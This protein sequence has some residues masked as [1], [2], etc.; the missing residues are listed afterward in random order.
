MR[1]HR[2]HLVRIL[3]WLTPCLCS[4]LFAPVRAQESSPSG[5]VAEVLSSFEGFDIDRDSVPEIR[6]LERCHDLE[7]Q[8]AEPGPGDA[9]LL[10]LVEGRLLKPAEAGNPLPELLTEYVQALRE[11]GWLAL[12]IR[13]E[14]YSGE[15]HQDGKTVLALRRML[16]AMRSIQPGF[17]GA[18]LIGSFPE[19]MLVRRWVWKHNTRSVTL[20][21]VKLNSGKGP[22]A[23]W[24][25]MD[26]ELIS[27]RSDIVL[28]DLDGEWEAIY[29]EPKTALDRIQLLP[30]EPGMGW[31]DAET[32]LESSAFRI[33]PKTYEDFFWIDD[34]QIEI[35]EQTEDHLRIRASYEMRRPEIASDDRR[36]PNPIARPEIMISR[37]DARHVAVTQPQ[38]NLDETG[39]PRPVPVA[40]GSPQRQ[41]R[42][43]PDLE[44][45]LL[46][47]YLQRNI[48][49]RRSGVPPEARRVAALTTDLHTPSKRYF[50]GIA[51]NL[52]KTVTFSKATA[53]DAARFLQTPA[54]IKGVSA[55]SSSSCSVLMK[56]YDAGE[57]EAL[58]GGRYWFWRKRGEEF[59]P[60]YSHSSVR[61][62]LH[63][64]LLRTLWTNG[65]LKD[66][67]PAFY[68]HGGCE[69]ISPKNAAKVPY[70]HE[71]YGGHDQIAESL[72]F[73]GNGLAL[74][75]RAKV[76]YDIPRGFEEAFAK[77]TFGDV[78]RRY[79]E[80]ESQDEK[81]GRSVASLNRAYF[82][83]ILG[84][85]TLRLP[86]AQDEPEG[87]KG[88]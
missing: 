88:H 9:L 68:V 19:A 36:Q 59:V 51:R 40:S 20:G 83:S 55:H 4:L 79:F 22:R 39:R 27:H 8:S 50:D 87:S 61:D 31:P 70:D 2:P 69:A 45:Q 37:L 10:I 23:A 33:S 71:S 60:S 30:A 53:V 12:P 56:G 25:A 34:S 54:L 18:I 67:G 81:L 75:G 44:R 21:G 35:L 63:F 11:D 82:W 42:R 72:L 49:Y 32:P 66:A 7:S 38:A 64:A 58:T 86:S 52:G 65:K 57:L 15:R 5:S 77:G 3:L 76:F 74:I 14:V 6:R 43:D 80:I 29:R 28:T 1:M 62:R 16:Q 24:L 26:P 78:L 73:Y 13:A 46:A 47:E 48:A 41:Y 85:W 17:Q 84:D